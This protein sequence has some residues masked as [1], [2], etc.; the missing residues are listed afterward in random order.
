MLNKVEDMQNFTK[1]QIEAATGRSATFAK[2][3]EKIASE[4]TA[5]SKAQFETST[6][7]F[8]KLLGTKSLE[9]A[10]QIQTDYAKSSYEALVAYST[11][12]GEIFTG[13]A[14]DAFESVTTPVPTAKN[15]VKLA[16]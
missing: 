2:G 1:T 10:I 9:E 4:T 15:A 13:H 5:L 16:A 6:A 8:T 12:V 11:K 7:A 3:F 14:K